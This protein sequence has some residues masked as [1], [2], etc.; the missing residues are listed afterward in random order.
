MREQRSLEHRFQLSHTIPGTRKL[1]SFVPI[2][3][4]T[5]EVKLYSASDVSRKE[6]VALAKNEIPPELIAGFV[7]CLHEE[8]WWLA[9][10][11][12]LFSDTKEVK[13]TFLHPHGPSNL[14]KYPE[15]QNIHTI[16]MDEVLTLVDPRTR[17]G[18][19]YSLTKKEMTFT[20][21]QLSAV[22][23]Q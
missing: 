12:E 15:P 21:K 13:L 2:S 4:S 8:N 20:T 23:P 5:V 14:F 17:S 3:D 22:S 18:R 10:V 11:L 16:P 6:R 19:V 9:S 1:H 7:T